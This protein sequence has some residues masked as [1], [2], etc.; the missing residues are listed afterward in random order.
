MLR[1]SE[2]RP[3]FQKG[4]SVFI[5]KLSNL[6]NLPV[7]SVSGWFFY[8]FKIS[9]LIAMEYL[10]QK[11]SYCLKLVRLLQIQI[12]VLICFK[13]KKQT[14]FKMHRRVSIYKMKPVSKKRLPFYL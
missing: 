8:R 9:F 2:V 5:I 13:L 10:A 1:L 12:F 11:I 14:C 3:E 7:F 4:L 6:C